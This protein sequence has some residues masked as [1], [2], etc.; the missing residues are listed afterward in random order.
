MFS[1]PQYH[2]LAFSSLFL[3]SIQSTCHCKFLVVIRSATLPT[4]SVSTDIALH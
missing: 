3:L 2:F 4:V 1:A